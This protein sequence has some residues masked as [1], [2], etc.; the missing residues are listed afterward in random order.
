VASREKLFPSHHVWNHTKQSPPLIGKTTSKK[1]NPPLRALLVVGK[2]EP[3]DRQLVGLSIV[4]RFSSFVFP[5]CRAVPIGY[6]GVVGP[7]S[8]PEVQQSPVLAISISCFPK[9]MN[10]ESNEQYWLLFHGYQ[11]CGGIY[12]DPFVFTT[13]L[14]TRRDADDPVPG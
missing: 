11:S 6:H 1:T 9:M 12:F 5:L 4:G 8:F 7:M 2:N 14:Q 10:C 13:S 3:G